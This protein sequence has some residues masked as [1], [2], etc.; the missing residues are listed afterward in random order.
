MANGDEL[1]SEFVS[2]GNNSVRFRRIN[3]K[4]IN[5]ALT[6]FVPSQVGSE[7]ALKLTI[8]HDSYVT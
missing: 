4:E 2:S 5:S 3:D 7:R 1:S 6:A 8:G